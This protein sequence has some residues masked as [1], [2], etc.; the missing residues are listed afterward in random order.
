M[1]P[2]CPLWSELATPP[3]R[4]A[5]SPDGA[6]RSAALARLRRRWRPSGS[7]SVVDEDRRRRVARR[8]P[9]VDPGDIEDSTTEPRRELGVVSSEVGE[10]LLHI[11]F[12][13]HDHEAPHGG[14][15]QRPRLPG[16]V[17]AREL[18]LE[19]RAPSAEG[20]RRERSS[21]RFLAGL[22]REDPVE[23][24]HVRLLW[25]RALRSQRHMAPLQKRVTQATTSQRRAG[26]SVPSGIADAWGW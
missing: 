26:G 13:P 19:A 8:W 7:G 6:S 9:Q 17:P 16:D 10:R 11:A 14:L 3:R 12:E 15:L 25:R 22:D 21:V 1:H 24:T 2:E 18:R 5:M 4:Q 23:H 20:L